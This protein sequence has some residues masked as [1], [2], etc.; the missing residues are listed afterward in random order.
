MH[1]DTEKILYS[2]SDDVISLVDFKIEDTFDFYAIGDSEPDDNL[3]SGLSGVSLKNLEFD[4][5]SNADNGNIYYY[6]ALE[7][8]ETKSLEIIDGIESSN[9]YMY[10][11]LSIGHIQITCVN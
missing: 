7:F 2:I 4:F 1:E 5:T 10:Q 3:L 6:F 8:N 9:C 11:K